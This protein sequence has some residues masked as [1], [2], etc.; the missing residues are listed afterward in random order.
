[1]ETTI[2]RKHEGPAGFNVQN[3][4]NGCMKPVLYTGCWN[5]GSHS[6]DSEEL[7]FWVIMPYSSIA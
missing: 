5:A 6:C 2:S 1:V 3:A 4:E 7:G